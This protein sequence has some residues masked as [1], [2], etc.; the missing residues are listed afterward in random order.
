MKK[1][2]N[3]KL[4][5]AFSIVMVMFAFSFAGCGNDDPS[6]TNQAPTANAGSAQNVTLSNSLTVTLDG[7]AST[8][9]DDGI[10][11]Y[12][13]TCTSYTANKGAVVTPYTKE[14][15]NALIT[16]TDTDGKVTLA[17]RKA[18]TYVFQLTVTDKSGAISEPSS[19]TVTVN[20]IEASQ[21]VTVAAVPFTPGTSLD[22]QLPTSNY[23][24]SGEVNS[25][26]S[27]DD[28]SDITYTLTS[29]NPNKTS[30]QLTPYISDGKLSVNAYANGDYP[31]ITQTFYYNGVEVESRKCVVNRGPL[32][33]THLYAYMLTEFDG[34]WYD[35][36]FEAISALPAF[37]LTLKKTVPELIGGNAQW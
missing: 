3:W 32:T 29:T 26:F 30:A 15:V 9:S 21:G 12:T 19:V 22:L 36:D 23:S 5:A 25:N 17:L 7:T 2:K 13:W 20:A 10:A 6:P 16:A 8:D 1:R 18:G 14:Q 4:L 24:F 37:T 33:F 27:A 11:S 35:T 28:L 31:T 34:E